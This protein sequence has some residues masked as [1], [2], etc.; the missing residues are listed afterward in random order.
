MAGDSFTLLKLQIL[1]TLC[2][3]TAGTSLLVQYSRSVLHESYS[4]VEVI[5]MA[6]VFKVLV[7]GYLSVHSHSS[8]NLPSAIP[9]VT[10]S[11]YKWYN[12]LWG[13]FKSGKEMLVL[14]ILYTISNISGFNACALIGAA[15]HSVLVQL[16]ILTTALFAVCFLQRKYSSTK[17]RA[18]VL[19]LMG[20][21]LV[22]SPVM[23]KDPATKDSK[24]GTGEKEK[25][26][27]VVL[28]VMLVLTQ[29]TISGFSSVYF[30]KILK[31]GGKQP[32]I[33]E[34]NFQLAAYSVLVLLATSVAE[35]MRDSVTHPETVSTA[36]FFNGWSII[37]VIITIMSGSTGLVIA[38]TLKY[39]DA[40]LKCLATSCAIIVTSVVGY[41][42]LESVI[43]VFV[44]IGMITVIIAVFN[45]TLDATPPDTAPVSGNGV[46]DIKGDKSDAMASAVKV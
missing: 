45:Y 32:N 20:A 14:V 27:G 34:R 21:I 4:T 37:T 10:S 29:A 41:F 24:E 43:D 35:N 40:V 28:G 44:S 2:F 5:L 3:L 18:L 46:G 26:D 33:W 7:S 36:S 19:L 8:D 25:A 38:A 9:S 31:K 16:K 42:F 17:W 1:A 23:S 13:L 22:T 11:A 39:A 15:W 12:H 30:E 6:E